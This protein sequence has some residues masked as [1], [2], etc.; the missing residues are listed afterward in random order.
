MNSAVV[1]LLWQRFLRLQT[2][3]PAL[4]LGLFDRRTLSSPPLHAVHPIGLHYRDE[5]GGEVGAI[6]GIA[7]YHEL[8]GA[9]ARVIGCGGMRGF[10]WFASNYSDDL[11]CKRRPS[12]IAK[13]SMVW[14]VASCLHCDMRRRRAPGTRRSRCTL[15]RH[16]P[17][18]PCHHGLCFHAGMRCSQPRLISASTA[19]PCPTRSYA[20]QGWDGSTFCQRR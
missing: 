10:Y 2:Q 1:T 14:S 18:W 9:L 7:C 19:P 3:V 13:E 6:D 8:H 4:D 16:R 12:G 15:I 11:A 17:L 5:F 20:T